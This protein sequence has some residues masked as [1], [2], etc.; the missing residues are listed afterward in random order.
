MMKF[1][2]T[3]SAVT[4]TAFLLATFGIG[5]QAAAQTGKAGVLADSKEQFWRNAWSVRIMREGKSIDMH[6]GCTSPFVHLY[7]VSSEN[8]P[9]FTFP[10][11][12]KALAS[13][14]EVADIGLVEFYQDRRR[15]GITVKSKAQGEAIIAHIKNTM[16]KE[17][18][19]LICYQPEKP[20]VI[21]IQAKGK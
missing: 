1:Q 15:L 2:K 13:F 14:P 4:A 17:N 3:I 18:P 8:K 11:T 21:D 16:P 19:R 10:T 5:S 9:D 7:D 12:R 6:D 20:R